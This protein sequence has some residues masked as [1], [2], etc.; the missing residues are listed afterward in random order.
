MKS[1]KIKKA[2]KKSDISKIHTHRL[3][4]LRLA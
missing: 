2:L 4:I 1:D 3:E